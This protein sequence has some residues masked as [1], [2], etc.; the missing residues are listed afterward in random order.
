MKEASCSY[1]VPSILEGFGIGNVKEFVKARLLENHYPLPAGFDQIE[2]NPDLSYNIDKLEGIREIVGAKGGELITGAYASSNSKYRVR[3]RQGHEWEAKGDN[4]IQGKW[5]A[6][7]A[8]IATKTLADV[9]RAA[10]SH[11]GECLSPEYVNNRTKLRFRCRDNHTFSALPA[12]VLNKGSW[13]KKCA[14]IALGSKKRKYDLESA[15]QFMLDKGGRFISPEFTI[16]RRT[17]EYGCSKGH[18]WKAQFSK[19]LVGD[20]CPHCAGNAKKTIEDLH[21]KAMENGGTCESHEYINIKF[22][23][24]WKCRENHSW[25]ATADSVLR[26]SWCLTCSKRN[27]S[28]PSA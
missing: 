3:C 13:C 8:G 27:R 2:V 26:G 1:T 21:R 7:C 20:W 22:R 9:Q 12:N 23:Y 16:T 11:G 15:R 28:N 17:Y 24:D 6:V 5:C 18:T 10:A 14:S 19:L 4:L 25:K